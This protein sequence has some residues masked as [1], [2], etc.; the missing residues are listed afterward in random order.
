[1]MADGLGTA[2]NPAMDKPASKQD[3]FKDQQH[4][5]AP[6]SRGGDRNTLGAR[7]LTVSVVPL[8]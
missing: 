6:G 2:H 1:M 4:K 5:Y 3:P 7:G 8:H